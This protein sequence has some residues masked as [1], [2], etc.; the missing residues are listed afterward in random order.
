[1]D[2]ATSPSRIKYSFGEKVEANMCDGTATLITFPGENIS[3]SL[4]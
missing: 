3:L 2:P 4:H 1:M